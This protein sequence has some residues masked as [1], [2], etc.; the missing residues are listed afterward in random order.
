MSRIGSQRVQK[1]S[2]GC[3]KAK[4]S[5]YGRRTSI[6]LRSVQRRIGFKGFWAKTMAT[7]RKATGEAGTTVRIGGGGK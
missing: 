5:V 1:R 7:P 3:L 2:K 4:Q 6:C